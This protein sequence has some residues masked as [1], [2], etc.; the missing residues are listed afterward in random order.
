[1]ELSIKG[2]TISFIDISFSLELVNYIA[3][4]AYKSDIKI[5]KF[6]MKSIFVVFVVLKVPK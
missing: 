4:K 1:M 2:A 6:T 5:N 3:Y